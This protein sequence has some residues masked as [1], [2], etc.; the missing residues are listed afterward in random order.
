MGW[1][2]F[3]LGSSQRDLREIVDLWSLPLGWVNPAFIVRPER[4]F[5]AVLG[6]VAANSYFYTLGIMLTYEVV[7]GLLQRNRITQLSLSSPPVIDDD[8]EE[9]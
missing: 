9:P 7:H 6:I 2:A 3:L 5:V 1:G 4:N 8:E